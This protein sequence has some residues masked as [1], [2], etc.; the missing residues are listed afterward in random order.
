MFPSCEP[1]ASLAMW[2]SALLAGGALLLG[3]AVA[4]MATFWPRWSSS[5]LAALRALALVAV[6]GV[7]LWVGLAWLR[8]ETVYGQL[9]EAHANDPTYCVFA[10]G[11]GSPGVYPAWQ[12]RTLALITPP[13]AEARLALVAAAVVG[14]FALVTLALWL[15]QRARIG[16]AP[17][18]TA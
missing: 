17:M 7:A 1:P 2:S 14:A 13:Q 5:A 18:I 3:V 9:V 6:A 11:L 10:G 8:I 16:R 12:R 15:R 4:L